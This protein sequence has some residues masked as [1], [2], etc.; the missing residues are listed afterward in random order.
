MSDEKE[1]FVVAL[2]STPDFQK[3]KI[4]E[5]FV[6][7]KSSGKNASNELYRPT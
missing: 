1:N 6:L 4:F 7:A 2:A 3:K 5:N